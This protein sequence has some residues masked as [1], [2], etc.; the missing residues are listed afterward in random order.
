MF[1]AGSAVSMTPFDR[2][3][4]IL[5]GRPKSGKSRVACTGRKPILEF[6]FDKRRESIAGIKDVYVVTLYDDPRPNIQPTS[7]NDF[8]SCM[9]QLESKQSLKALGEFV[10]AKDWQTWPDVPPKTCVADSI[11]AFAMQANAYA[12]YTNKDIRRSIKIGGK[13]VFFNNGWD[14]VN[15]EMVMVKEGIERM[16]ALPF[17]SDCILIFHEDNEET[18]S[19][20]PEK[21]SY[22][23]KVELYPA[24]YAKL[25]NTQWFSEVWRVSREGNAPVPKIQVQPEYIFTATSN[26]DFTKLKPEEINPSVGGPNIT[27]LIELATARMIPAKV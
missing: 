21:R 26:L 14:A 9:C 22:T 6:D 1:D 12:L 3:M 16:V 11:Q 27:K 8:L 17:R 10:K 25:F 5:M 4:L 15:A 13:E 2:L 19:S 7:Y 18:L 24:R 20:T 23:G